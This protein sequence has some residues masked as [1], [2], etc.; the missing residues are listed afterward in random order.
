MEFIDSEGSGDERCAEDGRIQRD[1][2]PHCWVMVREDLEFG[3]EVKIEKGEAGPLVHKLSAL[4]S[5]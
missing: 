4:G 1:N 3:V 5:G 2:L